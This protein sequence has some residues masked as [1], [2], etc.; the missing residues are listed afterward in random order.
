VPWQHVPSAVDLGL[1]LLAGA[2]VV[3]GF[4][5]AVRPARRGRS[6]P[7]V[8]MVVAP[9]AL[10]VAGLVAGASRLAV[11]G[12]YAQFHGDFGTEPIG[13]SALGKGVL[14]MGVVVTL[15]VAWTMRSLLRMGAEEKL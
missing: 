12:T 3:G 5:A 11:S 1:V 10:A 2:S 8:A 9:G 13:A 7:L 15:A 6:G 4:W 14:L